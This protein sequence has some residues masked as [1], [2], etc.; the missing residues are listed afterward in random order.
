[1]ANALQFLGSVFILLVCVLVA[2]FVLAAI[3]DAW[4]KVAN[5]R[6]AK[7]I[8]EQLNEQIKL[9]EQLRAQL[10]ESQRERT[11]LGAELDAL[12]AERGLT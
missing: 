5:Y 9:A 11:M 3:E 12:K 8:Q 10:A 4:R 7:R 6:S 2:I 1:M